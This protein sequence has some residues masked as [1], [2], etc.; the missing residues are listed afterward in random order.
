VDNPSAPF[1]TLT[2]SSLPSGDVWPFNQ[3][4]FLI[5]NV[6]VGGTLGGSAPASA[7]GPV[8]VNWIRYYAPQ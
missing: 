2:P 3:P 8:L 5:L 6:A 7:P 4:I 1:A